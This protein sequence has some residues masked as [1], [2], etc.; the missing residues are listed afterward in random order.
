MKKNYFGTAL[1]HAVNTDQ[2]ETTNFLET[3]KRNNLQISHAQKPI[4]E[5]N[6]SKGRLQERQLKLNAI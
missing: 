6:D 3:L 4:Y 1:M 5:Q 2:R